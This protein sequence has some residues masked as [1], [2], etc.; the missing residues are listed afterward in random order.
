MANILLVIVSILTGILLQKIRDFPADTPKAL[1]AYLIYVVLP[2]ISLLHISRLELSLSL[3]LPVSV[4]WII[5]SLTWVFFGYLGEK[6]AWKRNTTG[7]L[8]ICGGLSNTGF[9]GYP[10]IEAL[11]GIE[12]L[13]IA[14]LVDQP[15]SFLVVSSLAI[16]V[17][18]VY[19]EEKMRKRD[20]SRKMVFFPPFLFFILA[21]LLNLFQIKIEGVV[22]YLLQQFSAT[23]TPIALIAV[24]LQIKIKPQD[25]KDNFL[26]FG[27]VH[28]LFLVPLLIF[29]I[30]FPILG[31]SPS[32]N[33]IFKV[34]VMEAAM[35]S[36][37][38]SSII[39]SNFNL[40][41]KLA[42]LLVGIGIPLSFIS[43]AGWYFLL[44]YLR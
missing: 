27:L 13:K 22:E 28:K 41:P 44:E 42:S 15:G 12:G 9:V 10:I 25:I 34:S 4:A 14:V 32:Q 21:L 11:Y 26:W 5:F 40:R 24:G 1:N 23:L 7:C 29:I 20:I 8:I 30:Y 43:L 16:I 6:F 17:A 18:S 39:A 2:A 31:S 38:T 3:L 36:M 35:A 37:I 19:G 33:L